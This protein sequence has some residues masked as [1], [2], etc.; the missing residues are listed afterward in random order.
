MEDLEQSRPGQM[1]A[2]ER[3]KDGRDKTAL[4][5]GRQ[6]GLQEVLDVGRQVP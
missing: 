4:K 6:G 3:Q 2:R 1:K 5:L